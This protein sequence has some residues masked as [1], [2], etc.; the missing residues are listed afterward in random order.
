MNDALA[1]LKPIILPDAPGLWPLASGWWLVIVLT[2]LSVTGI[3]FWIRHRPHK[4][5]SLKKQL[6]RLWN[7]DLNARQKGIQAN[8]ILREWLF[9]DNQPAAFSQEQWLNRLV[10]LDP[11]FDSSPGRHFLMLPYSG[12]SATADDVNQWQQHLTPICK[13]LEQQK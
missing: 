8:L 7:T 3:W 5:P 4:K 9:L 1:D 10:Q 11:W 6:Q 12:Q 2:I 13:Q